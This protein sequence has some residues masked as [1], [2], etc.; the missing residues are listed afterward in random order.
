[1]RCEQWDKTRCGPPLTLPVCVIL[2]LKGVAKNEAKVFGQ[3]RMRKPTSDIWVWI[4][5]RN[6]PHLVTTCWQKYLDVKSNCLQY[7]S[8]HR[9]TIY[10]RGMFSLY[11]LSDN[12]G[13]RINL[14]DNIQYFELRIQLRQN[15]Y[16]H[17]TTFPGFTAPMLVLKS[18][19]LR[20]ISSHKDMKND[21]NFG[22]I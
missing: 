5:W 8:R 3:K 1:M 6:I 15:K 17:Q 16:I 13:S 11:Y 2:I 22:E 14:N 10:L 20:L 9:L 7:L 12:S 21:K 19:T 4:R 18:N